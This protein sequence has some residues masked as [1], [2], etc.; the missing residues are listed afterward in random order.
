MS[1]TNKKMIVDGKPMAL[2]DEALLMALCQQVRIYRN[3]LDR[4]GVLAYVDQ[5]N[6]NVDKKSLDDLISKMPFYNQ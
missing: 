6:L 2:V 3:Y 1:D 4:T 5:A